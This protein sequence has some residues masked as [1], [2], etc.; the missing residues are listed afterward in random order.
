MEC[1]AVLEVD[2]DEVEQT[3]HRQDC[4]KHAVVDDGRVA[5]E[6]IVDHVANEGHDQ[7][8]PEELE[9]M[10][11]KFGDLHLNGFGGERVGFVLLLLR[12]QTWE[13]SFGWGDG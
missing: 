5:A 6:G 10:K 12:A 9:A 11:A 4:D 3:Q 1:Q 8:R 7:E 2:Q 13:G